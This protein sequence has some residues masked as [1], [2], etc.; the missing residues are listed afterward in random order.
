MVDDDAIIKPQHSLS[1]KSV[2]MSIILWNWFS[3]SSTSL[4]SPT[5]FL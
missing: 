3:T 2:K 4:T 1:T 5:K